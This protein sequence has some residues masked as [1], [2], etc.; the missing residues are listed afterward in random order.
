MRDDEDSAQ[1][2]REGEAL[3]TKYMDEVAPG[4]ERDAVELRVEGEIGGVRVQSWIDVLDMEGRIIDLKTAKA[5]RS[6]RA[7]ITQVFNGEGP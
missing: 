5:P 4:V 7:F 3:L 1:L 6:R 2:V